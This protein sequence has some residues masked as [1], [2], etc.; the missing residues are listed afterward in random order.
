ML[1][2]EFKIISPTGQAETRQVAAGRIHFAAGIKLVAAGPY[3]YRVRI[4]L[5]YGIVLFCLPCRISSTPHP[6]FEN[7]SAQL[8]GYLEKGNR[9]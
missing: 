3:C 8:T 2:G 7:I 9:S 6:P 5:L 4:S 1:H